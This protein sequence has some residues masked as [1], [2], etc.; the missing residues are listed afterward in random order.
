[1]GLL[2]PY[3]YVPEERGR[4]GPAKP[5][6]VQMG[7]NGD[8]A[9]AAKQFHPFGFAATVPT[10]SIATVAPVTFRPPYSNGTS[11]NAHPPHGHSNG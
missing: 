5:S 6:L 1:M 8:T 4:Y 2:A 7:V 9:A 10:H 11:S 3:Y